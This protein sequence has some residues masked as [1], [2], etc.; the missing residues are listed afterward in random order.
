[1]TTDSIGS[2]TFT[3]DSSDVVKATKDLK[4]MIKSAEKLMSILDNLKEKHGINI[5]IDAKEAN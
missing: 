3:V 5:V 4:K 1:M 2:M